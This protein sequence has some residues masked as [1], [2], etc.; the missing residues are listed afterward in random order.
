MILSLHHSHNTV[1]FGGTYLCKIC[2]ASGSKK[3]IKLNRPTQHGEINLKAFTNGS[4]P[5]GFPNWRC[6]RVNL[7]KHVIINNTQHQI[8]QMHRQYAHQYEYPESES[9][10]YVN[11]PD[12]DIEDP[13]EG[14]ADSSLD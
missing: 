3:W 9:G 8:Y 13:V 10:A 14:S 5:A 6:K 4:K 1:L 11:I 2:G 12:E 7:M